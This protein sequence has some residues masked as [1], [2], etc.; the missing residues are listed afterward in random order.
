ML[1]EKKLNYGTER[2]MWKRNTDDPLM[3]TFLDKYHLNLLAIPRE[4]VAVGDLYIMDK[5]QRISTSGKIIYFLEPP[6][7]IPQLNIDES[8]ADVSGM[9]SKGLSIQEGFEL[10]EG[11]LS[12][13]GAIGILDKV[14]VSYELKK[15]NTMKFRFADT[16]RDS[17]DALLLGSKLIRHTIIED[18]P[19]YEKGYR[20]YLVTAVVRTSSISITAESDE[21]KILDIDVDAMSIGE[22]TTGISVKKSS[23]TEMMFIG[24]KKLTFGV[25]LYELIYDKKRKKLEL[26]IPEGLIKTMGSSKIP[27]EPAFIGGPDDNTHIK[28]E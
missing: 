9:L 20:Y 23:E 24:K 10:L 17:V 22:N 3:R 6:L 11:F 12:A 21:N 26:K 5:A 8:M 27:I 28:V 16:T 1:Q 15:A 13:F 14:R 2:K 4:N 7:E 19:L 25:E 18:H